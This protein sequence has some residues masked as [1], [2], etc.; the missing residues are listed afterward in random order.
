MLATW[1]L[2]E[3]FNKPS[4]NAWVTFISSAISLLLMLVTADHWHAEGVAFSRLAGVAITLPIVIYSERRFLSS[5]GSSTWVGAFFRILPAAGVLILMEYALFAS[6]AVGWGTFIVGTAIC[7]LVY[8]VL[9]LVTKFIADDE[10][11]IIMRLLK[12]APF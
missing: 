10:R 8:G 2:N 3:T 6:V 7:T 1:Q 5:V 11:Q 4:L 9:L 12:L